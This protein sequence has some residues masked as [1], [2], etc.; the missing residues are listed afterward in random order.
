[1]RTTALTRKLVLA[2]FVAAASTTSP[3]LFARE[4]ARH[5][6]PH[7][8]GMEAAGADGPMMSGPGGQ[9]ME[10]RGGHRMGGRHMGGP[11][12]GAMGM[13]RGLD[14]SEEQ[15]DKVFALMHGQAPVMH[16]KRKELAKARTA[17]RD[18]AM[19]TSYDPAKVAQLATAQGR[20]VADMIV[21]RTETFSKVFALLT[22]EQQ[23]TLA[24]RRN[25]GGRRAGAGGA[26]DGE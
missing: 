7:R 12:G 18:A 5:D 17:L 21:L 8:A 26:G 14:L 19:T 6:G 2:A 3:L 24:E 9:G 25:R 23:R 11:G 13:L 15:R 10:G 1:M 4:D 20:L 22:P 16:E